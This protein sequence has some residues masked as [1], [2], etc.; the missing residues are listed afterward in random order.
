MIKNQIT[1]GGNNEKVSVLFDESKPTSE[2][3]ASKAKAKDDSLFGEES[4][5]N[6][7][8]KAKTVGDYVKGA[9]MFAPAVLAESTRKIGNAIGDIWNYDLVKK[10]VDVRSLNVGQLK[11]VLNTTPGLTLKQKSGLAS[12]I[13]KL[14]ADTGIVGGKK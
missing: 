7:F 2:D 4:I 13:A 11:K 6:P 10:G 9:A 12:Q 8:E 1:G 5:D 14:Q 3:N